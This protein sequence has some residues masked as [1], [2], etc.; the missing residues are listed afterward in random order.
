MARTINYW[1]WKDSEILAELKEKYGIDY[2]AD[3]FIRKDA[4]TLLKQA[5]IE[6]GKAKEMLVLSEDDDEQLKAE[7]IE[8]LKKDHPQLMLSRV[9][10]HSTSEQDVPYVFVGHNGRAFYIPREIEVDV[11]DYILDSCIANAVEF[12]MYP[13]T[14]TDGTIEWKTKR[15]QRYPYSVIK[16]SFPAP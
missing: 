3:P 12:R 2:N 9:I 11:P 4:I 7:G 6:A 16:K 1:T 8:D 15:I 13:V 5:E 10:F 14:M